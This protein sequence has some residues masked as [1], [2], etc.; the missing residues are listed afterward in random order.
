[1]VGR[2]VRMAVEHSLDPLFYIYPPVAFYVFA[3]AEAVVGM[4]PGG[5]LGP[6]TVVNPTLEYLAA[7][8][9]SAVS[10]VSAVGLTWAI[11]SRAYGKTAGVVAAAA[12]AVAPLAVREAHFATTDALQTALVALAMWSGSRAAR[13]RDF[14]LAGLACAAATGTKYTAA[15]VLVYVAVQALYGRSW[16][17][18][19]GLA[20]AAVVS[21]A[22]AFALLL[23]ATGHARAFLDGILFLSGRASSFSQMPPGWLY[24]A[25]R[26]LPF[27]LGLGAYALALIGVAVAAA[28]RSRDD[29]ALLAFLAA[30][31]LPIAV[32][33]EVFFRYVLPLLP[34]LCILAG[35]ALR[36]VSGRWLAPTT[37]ACMLL[38]VPSVWNSV[39]GDRLLGMTDT[40]AEAAAWLEANAPAGSAVVVANYWGQP[41][42][43]A[44]E[45]GHNP[46][47]PLYASGNAIA[48]SFQQGRFTRRFEMT[49][50]GS[51][52]APDCY[53]LIESDPPWQTAT[54]GPGGP[55]ADAGFMP[56]GP[57]SGAVYDPLDSFYLPIWGFDGIERPGPAILLQRRC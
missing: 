23:L 14:A 38:L 27:G 3:A 49:A 19:I 12:L 52:A 13:P 1:M 16:R 43:S 46:L 42:Y 45:L 15:A 26:S 35:G 31:Y 17:A 18:G 36:A 51:S 56:G 50:G 44:N 34:A 10:A 24:H 6:A 20:G 21:F 48:D 53:R 22:V 47:H 4:L 40:R 9:V 11:A 57:E 29:L 32:S 28:R 33:H 41:F 55:A 54:W 8:A 25:T 30:G 37:A 39:Q 5:H 7:R 2:A